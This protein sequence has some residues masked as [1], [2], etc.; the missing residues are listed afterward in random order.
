[1]S[2][3]T[4]S[5][6]WFANPGG[7]FYNGVATQSLKF[8]YT[9]AE[10]WLAITPDAGNRKT[11]TLSVWVKRSGLGASQNIL[12][13]TGSGDAGNTDIWF[14]A[15]DLLEVSGANTYFR[16]TTQRFR[17]TSAW[18][19]LVFRFDTTQGTANNRLLIYVNGSVITDFATNNNY[20]QNTDYG[21]GGNVEHRIGDGYGHFDG[22]MARYEFIDGLSLG[23]EN[24]GETKNGVWI[25]KAYGGSYGTNGHKLEFKEIGTSA[26]SSGLGADTSGN[27]NHYT[28][29][30]IVASDSAM[31]DSP[32]NNFCTLNPL[33]NI[34]SG[35]NHASVH[36]DGNL[37]AINNGSNISHLYG[38]FRINDFLTNGCYFEARIISIDTSRFYFGIIDP[39]SYTGVAVAS[40]ENTQ[41]AVMNHLNRIFSN[42]VSDGNST[43]NP[44]SMAGGE[45]IKNNDIVG[46]AIKGDNVWF[47]VNGVYTKD[48]SNTVGNPSS[49]ANPAIPAIT[50]IATTD[51]FPYF[52]Y[53]SDYHVNFGQDP[54]FGGFLT[55]NNVG[56]ETADE[57]AGVFK[58]DVPTGF[59]AMCSANLVEPDIGAN[60]GTQATDHF[61]PHIYGGTDAATRTFDIGFVSDWSWFKARNQNNYGSQ[62]YDSSRG[63]TKVIVSSADTAEA[64][65]AAGVTDFDDSGNLLKIGTD[66]FLNE[67]GTTM[68]IWNWKANGS[69]TSTVTDGT[70]NSTVQTNETAGFSI[71][72]WTGDGEDQATIGHG[73]GVKPSWI[74]AKSRNVA[75]NWRVWHQSLSSEKFMT[76]DQNVV[77]GTSDSVWGT[78][79]AQGTATFS[80]GSNTDVNQDTKLYVAYV[81]R[82][83]TGYSKFG[84][85][86]GN[87]DTNGPF[88]FTGF[89]PAWIMIKRFDTTGSWLIYDNARNPDNMVTQYTFA[90]ITNAEGSDGK[91]DFLSNGFKQR[92]PSSYT[93]DNASGGTYL[94]MA[95][96]DSAGSF[97]YANA[98]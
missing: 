10:T 54:G 65:N 38:T 87:A 5:S 48:A 17:D 63:E 41:K 36:S 84:S 74:I 25:A 90:D 4:G 94:Y 68:V 13:A 18:Y 27:G 61:N 24:F 80:I 33:A 81:F 66:A 70:I 78:S 3:P 28:P 16:V 45:A 31:P 67:S 50:A 39:L 21:I 6:Q 55:G 60:S 77:P 52:G 15:N 92:S 56:T 44:N 86:V 82:E 88:V 2:S 9:S 53:A 37:H 35:S 71:V 22:Y 79:P 57:G 59:Q 85:Y 64:T 32:E 91:V 47:H 95:F 26:N 11:H 83:I 20:S 42:L 29:T 46:V 1:M 43:F 72:T 98:R 23:P 12:E 51:Y 76:L 89:R 8:A 73:L 30:A 7:D 97:K 34:N 96:A 14:D 58:Y 49:G 69:T 19:H 75:G 40:Y 62:L 93:D